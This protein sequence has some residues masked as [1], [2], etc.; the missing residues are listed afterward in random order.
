MK[1]SIEEEKVENID[2]YEKDKINESLLINNDSVV[3]RNNSRLKSR[4]TTIEIGEKEKLLQTFDEINNFLQKEKGKQKKIEKIYEK[5]IEN[6]YI[7]KSHIGKNK[8]GCCLYFTFFT[9]GPL[10]GIIYLIGIFQLKPLMKALFDL[11]KVSSVDYYNCYI[12]SSNCNNTISTNENSTYYFYEYYYN[13]SMNETIDFNLIMIT[14]FIGNILLRWSG[15]KFSTLILSVFNFGSILWLLNLDFEF[16]AEGAFILKI[17]TLCFI[18]I[19]LLIG[20]GSSSLLSHQILIE[21]HLKYKQF[22]KE[23]KEEYEKQKEKEQ[24][25]KLEKKEKEEKEKEIREKMKEDEK[26]EEEEI[27]G[28]FISTTNLKL[29]LNIG[30]QISEDNSSKKIMNDNQDRLILSNKTK[31]LNKNPKELAENSLKAKRKKER[32]EQIEKERKEQRKKK[33]EEREN[34]KFDFFVMICLITTIGYLGKYSVNIVLDLFLEIIYGKD[35]DKKIYM[36]YIMILYGISIYLAFLFY[37]IFKYSIFEYDEKEE[38]NKNEKSIKIS[39]ICGYIIYSEKKKSEQ[40]KNRNCC[41]LL[42]CENLQNC[43]NATFCKL[44]NKRDKYNNNDKD[45]PPCNCSCCPYNE[46]DYNKDKEEFCYCYKIHRKSYWCNKFLTNKTQR[47]IFPYMLLYFLLQ[48]TTI[49]FEKHYEKHKNNQIAHIK[50]WFTTF[51]STFILFFYY[52][53]SFKRIIFDE[54]K[55]SKGDE[56]EIDDEIDEAITKLSY[57]ILRGTFGVLVFNGIFSMVFSVIYLSDISKNIKSFFFEDYINIIFMPTLM[58]KFYYLTLNY[59][60]IYTAEKNKRFQIIS[61]SALI[62]MYVSLWGIIISLIQSSIPDATNPDD[63]DYNNILYF[64]QIGFSSIPVIG[65][66]IF[67]IRGFCISIGCRVCFQN[68]NCNCDECKMNFRLHEFLCW[69]FSWIFCF[70]GLWIKMTDFKE[71]ECGCDFGQCCYITGNYCSVYYLNNVMYCDCCCC[72]ENSC[73]SSKCCNMYCNTCEFCKCC[74]ENNEEEN[75][76]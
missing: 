5:Y 62:S 38:D 57:E 6:E 10:F 32:K 47:D 35:Y 69:L 27:D 53:L 63:Y 29:D 33:D 9:V 24:K 60:S 46:E 75:N 1:E 59:Y 31:L 36:I 72:Y 30:K 51:I 14:G 50:T 21:S 25:E 22:L 7:T 12:S 76:N 67:I 19:L 61:A 37:S 49:G 71:Y 42:F 23:I 55:V 58:N 66:I 52:T 70:G 2:I 40:L 26:K 20:I 16:K 64:I 43:C 8:Q 39:E 45:K 3:S 13:Y 11:I 41:T 18:Y 15:F 44:F 73:C 48:L 4:E 68:G 54:N 34:N 28:L 65:V 74:G 56:D 17:L